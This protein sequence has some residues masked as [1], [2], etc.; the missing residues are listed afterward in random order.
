MRFCQ[1]IQKSVIWG[2][3]C[4]W[5]FF[6]AHNLATNHALY[7]SSHLF[8]WLTFLFELYSFKL[9]R[10]NSVRKYRNQVIWGGLYKWFFFNAHNL[11]TNHALYL[12]SHL[13]YWLTFLFKLYSFKVYRC[14]Y[15]RKYRNQLFGEGYI[16]DS[17]SMHI[18]LQQTMICT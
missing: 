14:D 3:L 12:S 16:S 10:C 2:G 5:F 1:K 15:V 9:Y 6:N 4:R 11:A 18:I 13:F 7:L 17:F 8:Y